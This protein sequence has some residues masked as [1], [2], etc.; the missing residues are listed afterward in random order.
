MVQNGDQYSFELVGENRL[1]IEPLTGS[2]PAPTS[3][4]SP[5]PSPLRSVLLL[6]VSLLI[7][8]CCLCCHREEAKPAADAP[9]C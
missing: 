9:S 2:F 6:L 4:P 5:E 7:V 1:V 3:L 8:A